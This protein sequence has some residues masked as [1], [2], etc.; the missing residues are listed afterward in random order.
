MSSPFA[1]NKIY[2]V[3]DGE[4]PV[5]THAALALRIKRAH[6]ELN[7]VDARQERDSPI[8]EEIER[9][10]LDLDEGMVIY[11]DGRF[12]HGTDSLKFMARY[13]EPRN[14]FMAVCKSLFWSDSLARLMYPWMRGTRNWLLRRKGVGRIDNLRIAEAPIFK[15]VFGRKWDDLPSVLRKRYASRPYSDA[16]T[17]IEGELDV[18]CKAPLIWLTWPMRLAGQIPLRNEKGVAVSVRFY[19]DENSKA[20]HFDRHF[21]FSRRPYRFKSRMIQIEKNLVVEIMRLGLA[22][23]ARYDWDG[24]KVV[25]RHAGYGLLLFGHLLPIP[26]TWIVGAGYAEE[27][28]VDDDRFQFKTLISHPWWGTVYGYQG[29]FNVSAVKE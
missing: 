22:W 5:C 28:P 13:G 9:R 21:D 2:F 14:G 1:R 6:G 20:C 10:G 16:T 23:K 4:C 12:Y 24:E 15:P 7:L 11:A 17:L 27:I 19:G 8:V 25:I 29:Q 18:M 26:L 3:Y